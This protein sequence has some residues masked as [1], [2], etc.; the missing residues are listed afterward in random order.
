[1]LRTFTNLK[2]VVEQGQ[3]RQKSE[4]SAELLTVLLKILMFFWR[5]VPVA[6]VASYKFPTV[7]WRHDDRTD[8]HKFQNFFSQQYWI[9][10]LFVI[11]I[12][13]III[14]VLRGSR[15]ISL[16]PTGLPVHWTRV[17]R[18]III[19]ILLRFLFVKPFLP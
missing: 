19:P 16:V 2:V 15:V 14:L 3:K 18:L 7:N 8:M 10:I 12:I 17:T 4:S 9:G 5:S 1:M 6:I 13:I 11:I